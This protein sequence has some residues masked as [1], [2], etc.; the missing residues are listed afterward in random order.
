MKV[1]HVINNLGSGGAE[2]MLIDFINV[3]TDVHHDVL[4][5]ID[6]KISYKLPDN[7][8][9]KILSKSD[10]RFSLLKIYQ[11]YKYVKKNN[12]DVIHAHLFPTQYYVALVKLLLGKSIKIVTTE[13]NTTNKRRKYWLSKKID[14]FIYNLYDKIIF[15]SDGV[16]RQFLLDFPSLEH[17]GI[18]IN[19]GINLE[20]FF[21][22]NTIK[23]NNKKIKLLMVARFDSQKDHETLIKAMNFLDEKYILSLAGEGVNLERIKNLVKKYNLE[24]RVK[25]LGFV[26]DIEKIY[27]KHDIFILSSNWEGFGLVAI[28]AM[29]SGLPVIASNVEGL[30]EV[31]GK[32]GLLFEKKNEKDLA[33]KIK[34]LGENTLIKEKYIKK[35]MIHAKNFDIKHLVSQ[36]I[37][38]YKQL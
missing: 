1:L 23:N 28:E 25:F 12:Y 30:K 7:F 34:F 17:K 2:K 21:S 3:R 37:K 13:H 27:Q 10:K 15:I 20:S 5:L 26:K 18:V 33:E 24:N 38:L 16:K 8:K 29:A 6:N 31:V 9:Y 36:T 35:G 14:K 22:T 32:A 11:L 19:N 4:L